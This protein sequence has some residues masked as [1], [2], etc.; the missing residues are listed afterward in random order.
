MFA[1][2]YDKIMLRLYQAGSRKD[3]DAA[4]LTC[5]L[6]T[7]GNLAITNRKIT[8]CPGC[9]GKCMVTWHGLSLQKGVY[10]MWKYWQGELKTV[11]SLVFGQD[12][13]DQTLHLSHRCAP[14]RDDF[15]CVRPGHGLLESSAMNNWR[16]NHHNGTRLCGCQY[17]CLVNPG[18]RWNDSLQKWERKGE[19]HEAIEIARVLAQRDKELTALAALQTKCVQT[20]DAE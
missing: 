3:K 20:E 12:S 13:R 6:V 5:L 1:I 2:N 4:D 17:S 10:M 15:R 9:P 19:N 11:A 8:P 18:S 14:V 7:T 16:K